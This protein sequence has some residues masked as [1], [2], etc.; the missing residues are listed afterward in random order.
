MIEF[1][2]L[3]FAVRL[4]YEVWGMM[5]PSEDKRGDKSGDAGKVIDITERF[6]SEEIRKGS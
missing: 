6:E 4:I 5:F 3:I 2:L 1:C